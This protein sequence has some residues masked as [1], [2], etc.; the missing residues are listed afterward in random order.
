MEIKET[1]NT[2]YFDRFFTNIDENR[3]IRILSLALQEIKDINL[4]FIAKIW[5]FDYNSFLKGKVNLIV[6]DFGMI[7]VEKYKL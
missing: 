2:D 5:N 7:Q 1:K 4:D 6:G 3:K